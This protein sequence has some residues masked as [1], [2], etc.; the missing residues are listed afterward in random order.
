MLVLASLKLA[1]LV[2]RL[3]LMPSENQQVG[4]AF[5]PD[6]HRQQKMSGINACP[7]HKQA[8]PARRRMCGFATHAVC[9]AQPKPACTHIARCKLFSGC[10]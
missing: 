7:T 9:R 4:R 10:L 6:K 2:F 3:P 1:S 8:Q 5:T